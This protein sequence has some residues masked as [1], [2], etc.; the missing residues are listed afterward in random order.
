ML[1]L[2]YGTIIIGKEKVFGFGI[3]Q[4]IGCFDPEA[5]YS[6]KYD[7]PHWWCW[8]HCLLEGQ[9][10]EKTVEHLNENAFLSSM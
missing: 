7:P 9:N 10:F 4:K 8:R 2:D 6:F 3:G 5:A 1:D